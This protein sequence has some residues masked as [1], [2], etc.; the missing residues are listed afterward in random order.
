MAKR[1]NPLRAATEH[2]IQAHVVTWA[3]LMAHTHPELQLLFAIPN[4]GWRGPITGAKLKAEGVLPGVPDLCL[5]V[6]RGG[7]F[8][9]YIEMK[10]PQGRVSPVQRTIL[11]RLH[12]EG[13]QVAICY[14]YD[15]AIGLLGRYLS[16]PPTQPKTPPDDEKPPLD[17]TV[18]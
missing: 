5:P 6:A 10:T 17:D 3:R 16:H 13:Y 8:G 18:T 11:E 12:T 15:G 9:L 1:R 7:H 4:G 14:S 2:D